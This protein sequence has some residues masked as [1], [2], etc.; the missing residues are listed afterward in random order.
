MFTG[1]RAESRGYRAERYAQP[2]LLVCYP[3]K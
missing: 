1:K 3:V 2:T